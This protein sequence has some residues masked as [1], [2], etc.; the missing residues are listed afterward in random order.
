MKLW[1][2]LTGQIAQTFEGHTER[3]NTIAFTPDGTNLVS[4]SGEQAILNNWGEVSVKER[5]GEIRIWNRESG[6]VKA[7]IGREGG[8]VLSVAADGEGSVIASGHN[9][10]FVRFWNLEGLLQSEHELDRN[11]MASLSLSVDG[12]LVAGTG[13]NGLPAVWHLAKPEEKLEFR[14]HRGAVPAVAL[15]G[16][17][18]IVTAG[19][20]ATLRLWKAD[21]DQRFDKPLALPRKHSIDIAISP[22]GKRLA[23]AGHGLYA[24][25]TFQ[26]LGGRLS[27]RVG[28]A[29]EGGRFA[30]SGRSILN[31]DSGALV[32]NMG[33]DNYGTLAITDGGKY[34]AVSRG[35][36]PKAPYDRVFVREIE[37]G[38]SVQ[39]LEAG[40]AVWDLRFSPCGEILAA[41]SGDYRPFMRG[42]EAGPPG[43]VRLWHW[44][45]GKLLHILRAHR[46]PF[47]GVAFSPDGTRVAAGGGMYHS[48]NVAPNPGEVIVWDP[49]T[50]DEIWSFTLSECVFNVAFSPDGKRLISGAGN[51]IDGARS[52]EL[53]LW[54]METGL[55]ML[56]IA[57]ARS[58]VFKPIFTPDGKQ[59]FAGCNDGIL[60]FDSNPVGKEVYFGASTSLSLSQP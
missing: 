38:D 12:S 8:V 27:S 52:V 19:T 36:S 43:E 37:S 45:T 33:Q 54:N 13:R 48:G 40:Y 47:Y 24:L 7:A 51:I 18:H 14:G 23:I 49:L 44:R 58:T 46:L 30:T 10:G 9:D 31:A 4:G 56:S 57:G 17:S 60:V 34:A 55:E 28:F 32:A 26:M 5:P 25:P 3:I 21:Q 59:I 53:K 35:E 50:G 6:E 16:N 11:G 2:T 1:D 22:D 41:A 39:D 15:A 20:D 42:P 29:F